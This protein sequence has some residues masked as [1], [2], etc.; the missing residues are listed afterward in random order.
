MLKIFKKTAYRVA[1]WEYKQIQK[2]NKKSPLRIFFFA[3][4]YFP[5]F[6]AYSFKLFIFLAPLAFLLFNVLLFKDFPC[7]V[8][9]G[10]TETCSLFVFIILFLIVN[11]MLVGFLFVSLIFYYFGDLLIRGKDKEINK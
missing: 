4:D 6:I 3:I 7:V 11:I 9:E 2:I 1:E 8:I 5:K 10:G